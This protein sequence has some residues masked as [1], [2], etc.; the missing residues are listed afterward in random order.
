M[1]KIDQIIQISTASVKEFAPKLED[2]IGTV[3]SS[4]IVFIGDFG[5]YQD[6][7]KSKAKHASNTPE[8]VI[9]AKKAF[10]SKH[11]PIAYDD[12]NGCFI[13]TPK[14]SLFSKIYTHIRNYI[15]NL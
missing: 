15:N 4:K 13:K 8:C 2:T 5:V 12:R 6:Y 11:P 9:R 3:G 7:I 10:M 1:D 14:Q